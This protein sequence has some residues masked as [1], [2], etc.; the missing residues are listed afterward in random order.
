RYWKSAAQDEAATLMRS[1]ERAVPDGFL[2]DNNPALAFA[3]RCTASFPAAFPPFKVE[4][5]GPLLESHPSYRGRADSYAPDWEGWKR[6][7]EEYPDGFAKRY[8]VDG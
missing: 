3:A 5:V 7:F 6:A 2:R 4:D 1:A 8:F